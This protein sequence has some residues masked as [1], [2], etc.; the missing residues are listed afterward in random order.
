MPIRTEGM[1]KMGAQL[2]TDLCILLSFETIQFAPLLPILK[3][4]MGSQLWQTVGC[5]A[6]DVGAIQ[7]IEAFVWISLDS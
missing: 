4:A 3:V 2:V 1:R 7:R 6:G 5:Q